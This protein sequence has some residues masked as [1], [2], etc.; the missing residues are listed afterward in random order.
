[1]VLND[2]L[3]GDRCPGTQREGR[4]PVQLVIRERAHCG[5]CLTTVPA[6]EFER[7][8]LRDSSMFLSIL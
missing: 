4:R 1:M 5:G 3:R 7:L 2:E 8:R 6:Q